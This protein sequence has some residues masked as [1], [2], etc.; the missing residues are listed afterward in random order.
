MSAHRPALR[1]IAGA[2]VAAS[3][4]VGTVTVIARLGQAGSLTLRILEAAALVSAALAYLAYALAHH[5]QLGQVLTRLILVSAFGLWAIVQLAPSFS[6]TALLNDIVILLFVA[7]LAILLS[8]ARLHRTSS[9]VVRSAP[10]RDAALCWR[11]ESAD[12][13]DRVSPASCRGR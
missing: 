8:P 3:V 11:H 7:D 9:P 2:L 6:G 13:R 1:H 12:R 10:S 5:N 4:A